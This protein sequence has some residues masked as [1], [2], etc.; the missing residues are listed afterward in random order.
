MEVM[1]KAEIKNLLLKVS[2]LYTEYNYTCFKTSELLNKMHG[3]KAVPKDLQD[4]FD[5]A[6]RNIEYI[7]NNL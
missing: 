3:I 4:E 2:N 1:K 5:D 7:E 6:L